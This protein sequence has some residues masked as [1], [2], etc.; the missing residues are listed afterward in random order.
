MSQNYTPL[1]IIFLFLHLLKVR[2]FLVLLTFLMTSCFWSGTHRGVNSHSGT[3]IYYDYD[4]SSFNETDS[5]I[6]LFKTNDK[7]IIGSVPL[8]TLVKAFYDKKESIPFKGDFEAEVIFDK[9]GRVDSFKL[10]SLDS[11]LVNIQIKARDHN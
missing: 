11:N 2:Y 1:T 5:M 7:T 10:I 8:K 3:F 4:P 9:L 6:Y